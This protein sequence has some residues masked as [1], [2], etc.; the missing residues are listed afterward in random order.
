MIISYL[1]SSLANQTQTNRTIVTSTGLSS[2]SDDSDA[3]KTANF[4]EINAGKKVTKK[5]KKATIM[6]LM[7]GGSRSLTIVNNF[8]TDN[9]ELAFSSVMV[10][11]DMK[12]RT[13]Y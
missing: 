9:S 1:R 5:E 6:I 4:T 13:V 10:I 8:W 2:N 3:D 7:G 12:V 11:M